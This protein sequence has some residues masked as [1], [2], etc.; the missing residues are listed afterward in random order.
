VRPYPS[1]APL[2]QA[3]TRLVFV[4][5]AIRILNGNLSITTKKLRQSNFKI[6][7]MHLRES[8]RRLRQLQVQ[9]KTVL[10]C[11]VQKWNLKR[12]SIPY[13]SLELHEWLAKGIEC[14]TEDQAYLRSYD[15]APRPLSH[16]PFYCQQIVSLSQT[17]S[18][19]CWREGGG[20]GRQGVRASSEFSL[21][22][23]LEL[24]NNLWRLGAE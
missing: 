14:F 2:L 24:L 9:F 10:Y 1:P 16:P 5:Y 23:V 22:T 11:T 19:S 6:F 4:F 3:L 13:Q 7:S 15:L 21:H 12:F 20:E 18:V 8:C 17:F